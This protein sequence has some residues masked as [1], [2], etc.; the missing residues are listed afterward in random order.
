MLIPGLEDVQR[1]QRLREESHAGQ[2]HHGDFVGKRDLKF[3]SLTLTPGKGGAISR[4]ELRKKTDMQRCHTVS[5]GQSTC[6]IVPPSC[7]KKALW[8]RTEI[9]AAAEDLIYYWL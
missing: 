3:H 4:S 7:A 5:P 9:C 1:E 6:A 2:C 8:R